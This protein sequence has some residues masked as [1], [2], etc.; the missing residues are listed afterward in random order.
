MFP[1]VQ[2]GLE[3]RRGTPSVIPQEQEGLDLGDRVTKD[4]QQGIHGIKHKSQIT[5]N[6]DSISRTQESNDKQDV[7]PDQELNERF[8]K[9]NRKDDEKD[10]EG[11]NGLEE[12]FI[13]H[14][15]GM[16]VQPS[17]IIQGFTVKRLG[18]A[19]LLNDPTKVRSRGFS[20][21]SGKV[22]VFDTFSEFESQVCQ[23]SVVT[24]GT[25]DTQELLLEPFVLN[26]HNDRGTINT[27]RARDTRDTIMEGLTASF[28]IK[29]EP[30]TK[31]CQVRQPI[32]IIEDTNVTRSSTDLG[33]IEHKCQVLNGVF[34][35]N[36]IGICHDNGI[37][38]L[39]LDKDLE[40]SVHGHAFT[41]MRLQNANRF[42]GVLGNKEETFEARVLDGDIV[43]GVV[44]D[45]DVRILFAKDFSKDFTH[46]HVILRVAYYVSQRGCGRLKVLPSIT[47][48]IPQ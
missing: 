46:V 31:S 2:F 22:S 41:T 30:V 9:E 10:K 6:E 15:D 8:C 40:A 11:I 42:H 24:I 4:I 45:K 35:E 28:E 17:D 38:T 33:I 44:E 48:T 32:D 23:V 19:G 37:D 47:T 27:E 26:L 3:T 29:G 1:L 34:F 21:A 13:G 5:S 20:V 14:P 18:P 16:L 25:F 36:R 43:E 7:E 39:H 12:E